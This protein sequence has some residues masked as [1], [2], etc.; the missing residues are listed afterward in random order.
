MGA[1]KRLE[2]GTQNVSSRFRSPVLLV[3]LLVG[4]SFGRKKKRSVNP[5]WPSHGRPMESSAQHRLRRI[6]LDDRRISQ[7]LPELTDQRLRL[8][9][10]LASDADGNLDLR[11]VGAF[12]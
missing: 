8:R 12:F 4:L 9:F 2:S 1:L 6:Q 5:K 11:N 7:P 3:G 10:G